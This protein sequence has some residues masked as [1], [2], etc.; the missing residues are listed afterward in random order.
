[1]VICLHFSKYVNDNAEKLRDM[2]VDHSDKKK[3]TVVT[4]NETDESEW[5][6]FFH[7]MVGAIR[8]NTKNDIVDVLKADFTTTGEVETFLSVAAIMDSF[9]K[10][11]SYGRCIP[12]CGIRNVH[13]MGDLGDWESLLDRTLK[14]E[15]YA[16]NEAWSNYLSNL[17]P[18]L[19]KFI[20][21]Y[22][23]KVDVD[24]W[25][26]VMN[27]SHGRLGSGSTTLVSGWILHFFGIYGKVDTGDIKAYSIDVPVEIDNKL[28]GVK[29]MVNIVGGFGGV[30]KDGDGYRPQLSMIVFWD[31]KS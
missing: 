4:G 27:L 9:K 26:Q 10:Y 24:F 20:D 1:M 30:H 19:M 25:N 3:L 29:K 8:K 22:N 7:L 15:K 28:T 2:F 14:L 11:F 13:F 16:V 6:E 31:G 18:I 21:T 5:G 12:C 23:G 17:K